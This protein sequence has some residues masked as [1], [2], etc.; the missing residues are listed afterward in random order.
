MKSRLLI[1]NQ[2][3]RFQNISQILFT[4][5]FFVVHAPNNVAILT[6]CTEI[7]KLHFFNK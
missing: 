1:D 4:M 7:L 6:V 3:T 2:K 5:A